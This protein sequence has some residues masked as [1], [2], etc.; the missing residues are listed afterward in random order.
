MRVYL[1]RRLF[2]LFPVIL[3][4]VTIVFF[5]AH[6]IPGDPAAI[7]AGADATVE[8]V[9][10]MRQV[11]GLDRPLHEQYGRW[12]LQLVQGDLGE[13]IFLQRPVTT[14]IFERL[15]PTAMLTT[16]SMIVALIVGLPA[17]IL[18]GVHPNTWLDK[19]MMVIAMFGVAVPPFW[20]GL[21]LIYV[22]SYRWGLFPPG[23]YVDLSTSVSQSL[24]YMV[25]PSISL[26]F[27]Q[28]ALIARILRSCMLEVLAQDYI[29]VARAKGVREKT[30]IGVHALKN[31]LVPT[32]TVIGITV[33]VLLGGA[34][35]TETVF[36]LPGVGRLLI[37]SVLR[38][39]YPVIQGT[40]LFIGLVFV[41]V[42]LLVDVMYCFI[43]PR[44]RYDE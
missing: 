37:T 18:S 29:Q 25:L 8:D 36:N 3:M 13:S 7:M 15:E 10:R 12:L 22:F 11:M 4:V 5:L 38:R 32:S 44:I 9:E 24:Y 20:L 1:I 19:A 41:L 31:A 2:Y 27:G 40:V 33:A 23:N 30:V 34:V 6:L 28:S 42:N 35:V 17:G 16:L 26:G 43:D 39:D 21:N 14:A